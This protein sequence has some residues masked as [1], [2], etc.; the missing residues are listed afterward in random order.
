M[1]S[2]ARPKLVQ[3]LRKV[4]KAAGVHHSELPRDQ[5]SREKVQALANQVASSNAEE[6]QKAAVAAAFKAYEDTWPPEEDE[7]DEEDEVVGF[8]LR[9]TSFLL[10]YNWD[11]FGKDFPDGTPAAASAEDLWRLWGVFKAQTK[12]G[13]QVKKS[14]S[15]LE[16][17]L[18]S[19]L[20]GRVHFHWKVDVA[21]AL[22]E[23]N[24]VCFAFHG[25]K[26]D[27]RR[28]FVAPGSKAARGA[29]FA[30]SS[31]RGHFYCWAPKTGTL[32]KGTNWKPWT[33]Y[34]VMGKWLDDLWSDGKLDNDTYEP[35]AL[36][37]R[38]GFA[39]RKRNVAAVRAAE[40]EAWIDK[41]ISLVDVAMDKIRAPFL[42]FPAVRQWEDSFVTLD[43]RWKLLAL[44]ADSASGKSNYAESLFSKP[45]VLTVEEAEH[46]DLRSFQC[47]EHDGL[48]L[49]NCNSWAQLL[50][51]RAALQ[52]RNS[53]SRGGQSATNV[54]SYPQYLY[55]VAVVATVDW[56][57][58]DSYLVDENSPWRSRWLCKN[59]VFV[60]LAEGE[61]FY[62]KTR[63]PT[64][65]V[66]NT[67]SSFAQTVKRRR[68]AEQQRADQQGESPPSAAKQAR[69]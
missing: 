51:W 7:Q 50:R 12:K 65:K 30:E 21:T 10:T 24:T 63:V 38:V 60:R 42:T 16:A 11:F 6:A 2:D 67:F 64:E 55:G 35:L 32:Y 40:K 61:A 45:L 17:S 43:F 29:N 31:N 3:A 68:S 15:T 14:T 34:R 47:D 20:P 58:P 62:D 19:D 13:V 57:A 22:D 52:A 48:V 28:P 1:S 41:R 27:A 36:R 33:D 49:D 69:A 9:G 5:A 56:D 23:Q 25:V 46:L 44:V 66:D 37:V 53:K 4:A 8:R 54:Y 26:P 59:T 39:E 18:N